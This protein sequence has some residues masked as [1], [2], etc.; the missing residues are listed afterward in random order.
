MEDFG[1][2]GGMIYPL[3]YDSLSAN[4]IVFKNL[5]RRC[6]VI[7]SSEVSNSF[8]A[9]LNGTIIHETSGPKI[10]IFTEKERNIKYIYEYEMKTL[11]CR[12]RK[13]TE[14]QIDSSIKRMSFI[15]KFYIHSSGSSTIG[16]NFVNVKNRGDLS[17]C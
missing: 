11:S 5:N 9:L 8:L 13:I 6:S 7:L 4:E 15:F 10:C 3:L 16:G 1:G 12:S 2:D 17:C 14:R